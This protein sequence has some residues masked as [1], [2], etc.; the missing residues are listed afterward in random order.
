MQ[1]PKNAKTMTGL[2]YDPAFG[3]LDL[4]AFADFSSLPEDSNFI[5]ERFAPLDESGQGHGSAALKRFIAQQTAAHTPP[6]T[7]HANGN[8][9]RVFY[10]D[11][12]WHADGEVAGTRRRYQDRDR[13]G[14][15][16]KI[17]QATKPQNAYRA[18]T[19]DE[20]LQVIRSCQAGDK[21]TAIGIYLTF[22]IGE[23]RASMYSS[24]LEMMYDAALVPVM[25]KC[26]L[27]TWFHSH[28]HATDEPEWRAF[29]DRILGT[30]PIT[31]DLLDAI[32]LRY[33]SYLEDES[34]QPLRQ[35]EA[36]DEPEESPSEALVQL[37]A[38]DDDEIDDLMRGTQRQFARDVRAGRR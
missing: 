33:Q 10:R 9:F 28:P 31:F 36:P 22:A 17:A 20:E 37:N 19:K 25:N 13:D 21:L 26:A 18:L 29:R 3:G 30:R 11:N 2:G 16:S 7:V 27:F 38:L 14:L 23:A 5:D 32:W 12:A 1:T 34:R 35:I 15:L 4:S 8:E 6:A 24:P